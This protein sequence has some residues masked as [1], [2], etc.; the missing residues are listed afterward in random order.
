[1]GR[2]E[3][4]VVIVTGGGH[5]LGRA[6]CRGLAREG[7]RVVAADIDE[8]AA[9]AVADEIRGQGGE[10]IAVHCDVTQEASVTDMARI[11]IERFG[12]IH[13]LVNNAGFYLRPVPVARRS[14]DEI[15]VDEWDRMMAVNLRGVFLCARAVVPS[16]KAKRAGKI[17]NIS[18]GTVFVGRAG[19]A[20]YV[21]SKAGVIGFT[22]VLARELGEF[23]ITANA[24]APGLTMSE[25]ELT[26]TDR[27][28]HDRAAGLRCLT[29][30]EKPEDLVGIIVFLCSSD[31]DFMTGQ[32][33][34]V[35]GGTAFV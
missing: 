19:L 31:S 6:Y 22:R 4:R 15:P 3:Q 23:G 34:L 26:D 11:T 18:S 14:F 16:M 35:D 21:A 33:M 20:H 25:D 17:I 9:R 8:K 27:A 12:A 30:V 13:V 28:L 7:A 32:T 29:R 10:A 24:V 1:M 2:L 5:G